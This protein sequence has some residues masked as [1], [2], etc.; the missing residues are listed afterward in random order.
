MGRK[1]FVSSNIIDDVLNM[2]IADELN[3]HSLNTVCNRRDWAYD[4]DDIYNINIYSKKEDPA[5]M[6]VWYVAAE[7]DGI[8]WEK[9]SG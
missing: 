3:A 7:S 2:N 6:Y 1:V 8:S 4:L 5:K 9:V